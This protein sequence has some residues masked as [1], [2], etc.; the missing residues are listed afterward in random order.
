M[1][2]GKILLRFPEVCF[3]IARELTQSLLYK[4]NLLYLKYIIRTSV[5]FSGPIATPFLNIAGR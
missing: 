3:G 4:Y 2:L 5:Q 1:K